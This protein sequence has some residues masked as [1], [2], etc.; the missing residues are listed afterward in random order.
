MKIK[1]LILNEN[2]FNHIFQKL[3]SKCV[4]NFATPTK[5]YTFAT[6]ENQV[7]EN[8]KRSI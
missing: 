2:V 6:L 5:K 7:I 1:Y 3:Q 8:K 4:S